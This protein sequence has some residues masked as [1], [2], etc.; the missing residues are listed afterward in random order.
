[1][2]HKI[3][4]LPLNCLL[5]GAGLIYLGFPLAALMCQILCYA[6]LATLVLS[7]LILHPA[8]WIILACTLGVLSLGSSAYG[9]AAPRRPL[10]P[11][12]RLLHLLAFALLAM[13]GLGL[14]LKYQQHVL[15]IQV[16][17]V[18]SPSM[19]PTLQP[20]D[21]ILLD[22]WAYDRKP[23]VS[24][25]IVVFQQGPEFAVVKRSAH[26][27][28]TME[29]VQNGQIYVL[30]DNPQMSLDSRKLGGIDLGKVKGRVMLKLASWDASHQRLHWQL[31]AIH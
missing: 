9:L 2:L 25:D 8:A 13:L 20:G 28:G 29:S 5:P 22:S 3:I 30:G 7:R 12:K 23:P 26:W 14:S 17:F 31:A 19:T 18:P 27:P 6:V 11:R 21:F 24:G 10:P 16:Y 1:M 4:S 15:G